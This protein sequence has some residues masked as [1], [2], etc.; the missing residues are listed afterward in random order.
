M[1]VVEVV[2]DTELSVML[3]PQEL[4]V[5]VEVVTATLQEKVYLELK[6]LVEVV[7]EDLPIIQD[8]HLTAIQEQEG[9]VVLVSSLLLIQ[10]DK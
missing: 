1:L 7:E 10:P 4:V 3:K 5:L 8:H 6:T 2:Q 9:A